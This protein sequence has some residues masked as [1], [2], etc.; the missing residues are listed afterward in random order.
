MSKNLRWL[1]HPLFMAGIALPVLLVVVFAVSLRISR[2]MVPDPGYDA[3]FVTMRVDD[4]RVVNGSLELRVRDGRVTAQY[5]LASNTG[6]QGNPVPR[7]YRV[8]VAEGRMDRIPY[9]VP[10]Y[11]ELKTRNGTTVLRDNSLSFVPPET[12]G[13][14]VDSEFAAP[15]GYVYFERGRGSG[16]VVGELFGGPRYD[17]P[18]AFV[19]DGRRLLLPPDANGYMGRYGRGGFEFLG[20]IVSERAGSPASDGTTSEPE[21]AR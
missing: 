6:Y 15:D 5:T 14:E 1:I 21:D 12:A 10:A 20:W 4:E 18:P 16:G 8:H 13:L 19:K 9:E 7:L 2:S 11:E 3:L 17:D